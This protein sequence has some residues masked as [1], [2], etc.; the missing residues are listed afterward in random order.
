[1]S[2]VSHHRY[3]PWDLGTASLACDDSSNSWSRLPVAAPGTILLALCCWTLQAFPSCSLTSF[4]C[5]KPLVGGLKPSEIQLYKGNPYLMLRLTFITFTKRREQGREPAIRL[6]KLHVSFHSD[7]NPRFLASWVCCECWICNAKIPALKVVFFL[8][9]FL[10]KARAA[11]FFACSF[12]VLL[13][14][15]RIVLSNIVH[16]RIFFPP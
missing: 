16:L 11:I 8:T 4:L 3:F 14:N 1:M 9:S 13:L 5:N 7:Y 6:S 10:G 2:A 12:P 15:C